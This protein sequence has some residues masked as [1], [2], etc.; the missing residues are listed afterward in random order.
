VLDRVDLQK[1]GSW[2]GFGESS[3]EELSVLR[4]SLVAQHR[5]IDRTQKID[6]DSDRDLQ[7]QG[8]GGKCWAALRLHYP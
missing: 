5:G 1:A 3:K 2:S 7:R 4:D 6:I 8:A